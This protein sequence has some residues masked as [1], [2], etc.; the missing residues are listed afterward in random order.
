MKTKLIPVPVNETIKKL[1]H[2]LRRARIRKRLK[3]SVVE[4]K[5]GISHMTLTKVEKGDTSVSMGIYA[6]VMM[7]LDLLGNI[8]QYA[9][10]EN[11][12]VQDEKFKFV[13]RVRQS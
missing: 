4:E 7:V 12:D 5:A 8:N 10:P 1:G 11:D 9:K 13:K 3:M 2:D 6:K